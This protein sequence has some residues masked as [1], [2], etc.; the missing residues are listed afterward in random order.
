MGATVRVVTAGMQYQQRY[1]PSSPAG[2]TSVH[3][4]P[5]QPQ[6]VKCIADMWHVSVQPTGREENYKVRDV[7]YDR[8]L[9]RLATLTTNG[10]V[11]LW[12]PHLSHIRTERP[13]LLF[14]CTANRPCVSST[15]SRLTGV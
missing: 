4:R 8:Q 3:V 10:A 9:G 7:K 13:P 14:I 12:D 15:Y 11:Q 1:P 6:S 5:T 2:Q